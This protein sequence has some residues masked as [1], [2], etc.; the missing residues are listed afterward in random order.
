MP[1]IIVKLQTE[2]PLYAL[3]GAVFGTNVTIVISKG[4]VLRFE[5]TNLYQYPT[6]QYPFWIKTAPE[7]GQEN[8]V[9]TGI[10]GAGQGKM[11]GLLI[12]ETTNISEGTYYYEAEHNAGVGGMIRVGPKFEGT[13]MRYCL[14]IY[15]IM[16]ISY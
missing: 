14:Y 4:D 6:N 2:P 10:K 1:I 3:S 5:L 11:D 15:I 13:T 7:I 9:T 16:L 12:W 8:A